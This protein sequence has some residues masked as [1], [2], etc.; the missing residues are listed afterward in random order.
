M[1]MP[2]QQQPQGVQSL[3]PV[4]LRRASLRFKILSRWGH[5][6]VD[7]I[8]GQSREEIGKGNVNVLRSKL[9]SCYRGWVMWSCRMKIWFIDLSYYSYALSALWLGGWTGKGKHM[10]E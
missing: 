10:F 5:G 2:Q 3:D 7:R 8:V 1:D 6:N 4:R 9:P